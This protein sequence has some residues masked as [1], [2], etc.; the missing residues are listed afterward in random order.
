MKY[1]VITT[2]TVEVTEQE[3]QRAKT[4]YGKLMDARQLAVF[5]AMQRSMEVAMGE[6]RWDEVIGVYFDVFPIA[7]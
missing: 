2:W 3:I 5:K 4:G 6:G 7:S 1:K